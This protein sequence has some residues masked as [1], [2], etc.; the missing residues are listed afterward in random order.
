[1][2][3]FRFEYVLK[4]RPFFLFLLLQGE[5]SRRQNICIWKDTGNNAFELAELIETEENPDKNSKDGK[6][7]QQ[8]CEET[9]RVFHH[10]D[11]CGLHCP[12]P[13][14]HDGISGPVPLPWSTQAE[15]VGG[16]G[17]E[18]DLQGQFWILEK[19][20]WHT[21]FYADVGSEL[22]HV[23]KAI[24]FQNLVKGQ[25]KPEGNNIQGEMGR[26]EMV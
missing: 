26:S 18:E 9:S 23:Y 17:T 15:L 22:V 6:D 19:E 7:F 16:A 11:S 21:R 14:G 2:S 1:M 24:C 13:L 12:L 8:V 5:V 3:T 10:S 4:K 25:A 20:G